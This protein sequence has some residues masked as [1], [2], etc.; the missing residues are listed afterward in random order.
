MQRVG[1]RQGY[2]VSF[3]LLLFF[4]LAAYTDCYVTAAS[5]CL[6]VREGGPE[7]QIDRRRYLG[8]DRQ[9]DRQM[10]TYKYT[11]RQRETISFPDNEV[12]RATQEI[13]DI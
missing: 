11:E 5:V 9:T 4:L 1:E 2:S 10:R 13:L 7:R 3:C 8:R 12:K 6:C